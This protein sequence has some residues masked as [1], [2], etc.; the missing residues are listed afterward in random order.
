VTVLLVDDDISMLRIFEELLKEEG[1]EVRTALSGEDALK[2]L[3]D[4]TP[5]DLMLVDSSMPRMSGTEYL[6][7][8]KQAYPQV[9]ER[10]RIVGF[11]A[12]QKG[13]SVIREFESLVHELVEKPRDIDEFLD[14]IRRLSVTAA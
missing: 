13:A 12:F 14:F 11:T 4:G 6:S 1:H 8:V 7:N 10:T 5:P 2:L 3:A 9:Y